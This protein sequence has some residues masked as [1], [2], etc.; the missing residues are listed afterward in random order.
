MSKATRVAIDSMRSVYLSE[1]LDK[2]AL[3]S[4]KL[5]FGRLGGFTTATAHQREACDW[6]K[7]RARALA[8]ARTNILPRHHSRCCLVLVH[9]LALA[10]R[11]VL[12]VLGVHVLVVLVV[13]IVVRIDVGVDSQPPVLLQRY[14]LAAPSGP[15]P[16]SRAQASPPVLLQRYPLAAPSGPRPRS[17]SE[18]SHRVSLLRALLNTQTPNTAAENTAQT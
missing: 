13:R 2:V 4:Q 15:R 11:G 6:M 8:P 12:G 17:L 10:R 18:Q 16:R 3:L 9:A 1:K 5:G 7:R 14:P